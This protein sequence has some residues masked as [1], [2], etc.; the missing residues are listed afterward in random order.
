MAETS[1]HFYIYGY[2]PAQKWFKDRKSR[3]SGFSDARHYHNIIKALAKTDRIM[4]EID[5]VVGDR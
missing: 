2:Q 4:G 1:M 5:E 3:A